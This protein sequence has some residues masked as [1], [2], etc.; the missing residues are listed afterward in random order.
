MNT[1][2]I[3]TILG[4]ASWIDISF[5]YLFYT[6]Y[7]GDNKKAIEILSLGIFGFTTVVSITSWLLHRVLNKTP[8]L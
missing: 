2:I 1:I 8:D 6:D 5:I 7:L 4:I 3:V